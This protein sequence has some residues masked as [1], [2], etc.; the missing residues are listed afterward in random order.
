MSVEEF[1]NMKA[2][3]VIQNKSNWVGNDSKSCQRRW[4]KRRPKGTKMNT[5]P[6][7]LEEIRFWLR[8]TE[9]LIEAKG[10]TVVGL[11]ETTEFLPAAAADYDTVTM[12]AGITGWVNGLF[13]FEIYRVADGQQVFFRHEEVSCIDSPSLHAALDEFL[14]TL[15]T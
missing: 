11:R 6:L 7:T 12:T 4:S 10:V 3:G 1:T 14:R 9:K 13:D 8:T 15:M 2:T 5:F